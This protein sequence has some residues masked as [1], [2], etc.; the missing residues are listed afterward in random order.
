M[1]ICRCPSKEQLALDSA[2]AGAGHIREALHKKGRATIVLATGM[3]QA[4]M[5]S[6]LA[7]E[8]L[9]WGR[10]SALH[11]DEYVGIRA[12]H[13]ASF[14]KY[15][16][17]RFLR[18]VKLKAF[19]PIQGEK[20][21]VD[22]MK[23]LNKLV[24]EA[25]VDVAFVGIGENGHLAFNDPPAN[26]DTE[27][28]YLLVR[29]D[30]ACRRQ[31]VGEGWFKSIREVPQSA[32]TMSIRQILKAETIICTV[33]DAR[34]AKAV[35]AAMEGDITPKVPASYL[36]QHPR[37][38]VYVDP[39]SG[40]RLG[41]E[42]EP[43]LQDLE[44][45][46]QFSYRAPKGQHFHLFIAADFS[47]IPEHSQSAFARKALDAGAVTVTAWGKGASAMELATDEAARERDLE[48]SQGESRDDAV[49]THSFKQ[50]EFDDALFLF[51]NGVE[52][53]P[54]YATSCTSA[55]A[56][57]VG[58]RGPRRDLLVRHLTHPGEFIDGYVSS[59]GDEP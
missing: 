10:V 27:Q 54:A 53:S 14:R 48:R 32:I 58:L 30:E 50:E 12:T 20:N 28:P 31:Q 25:A 38:Y 19:Y 11:L 57:L 2:L 40:A 55:V 43:I 24:G 26:V 59:E 15:L 42:R 1:R 36:Q 4:G 23:R 16:Q 5:L 45:L 56:V 37:A 47:R 7:Q 41:P 9:D 35:Y 22:E 34:K 46:D 13:P 6:H 17:E 51:L 39:E 3:S 21:P 18:H 49:R 8:N 44:G 33:P 52:P 29:L